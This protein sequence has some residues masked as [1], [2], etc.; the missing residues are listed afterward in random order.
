MSSLRELLTSSL[1][2]INVVQANENPSADDLEVAKSA[3]NA[4]VDSWSTEHL[5]IFTVQPYRFQLTPYKQNYTL[6]PGGDW[7]IERPMNIQQ[8]SVMLNPVVI[9]PAPAPTISFSF[10]PTTGAAPLNVTFTPSDTSFISYAWDFGDGGTSTDIAPTHTYLTGG[11]FHASLTVVT[12]SATIT[13]SGDVLVTHIPDITFEL[14]TTQAS[15]Q[16]W[17]Q[18]AA[19]L[20]SYLLTYSELGGAFDTSQVATNASFVDALNIYFNPQGTQSAV[21][22]IT[23][24][25]ANNAYIAEVV[26]KKPADG[27]FFVGC[28]PSAGEDVNAPYAN[29]TT[30]YWRSDG[31]SRDYN[32]APTSGAPTFAD[33]DVLGVLINGNG[34]IYFLKNGTAGFSPSATS[35]ERTLNARIVVGTIPAPVVPHYDHWGEVSFRNGYLGEVGVSGFI[36]ATF[37]LDTGA[38]VAQTASINTM[39]AN[40][41]LISN[42]TDA[43]GTWLG[44][45]STSGPLPPLAEPRAVYDFTSTTNSGD[46]TTYEPHF[47]FSGL[48]GDHL[49]VTD[50]AGIDPGGLWVATIV[51]GP[52]FD[53]GEQYYVAGDHDGITVDSTFINANRQPNIGGR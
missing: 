7:S 47:F 22:S 53:V 39:A 15:I 21:G 31:T 30:S 17:A 2:L 6:G 38:L 24:P 16:Y 36:D 37:P 20:D 29:T 13:A 50:F 32:L 45:G 43:H 51:I 5:D 23:V 48:P 35:P 8:A 12:P 4:I 41:Y 26:V 42:G 10:T 33:G 14:R 9:A 11:T 3:F 19:F 27:L 44:V 34:G 49:W 40:P 46:F 18:Y 1:R 52:S 25:S 28:V